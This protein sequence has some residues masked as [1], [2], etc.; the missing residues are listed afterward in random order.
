MPV[1]SCPDRKQL[2][3][4]LHGKLAETLA[5]QLAEHL[6][7][8]LDCEQAM[9]EIEDVEQVLPVDVARTGFQ[10]AIERVSGSGLHQAMNRLLGDRDSLLVSGMSHDGELSGHLGHYRIGGELGRGGMGTVYLA[11][12]TRLNREVALKIPR[13][14]LVE[15]SEILERLLREARAA[16]ALR[17]ANICPIYDTGEA[18][19]Q[20][21]I[22]MAYIQGKMLGKWAA[23]GHSVR[24][25]AEMMSTLCAAVAYAHA[26]GIV[27]RDL[28]P[29]NVMIESESNAPILMDFG[30]AVD[31]GQQAARTT[32]DGRVIGTPAY[33]A[34]EQAA[35]RI[36]EVGPAADV[37]ALGAILYE[38]LSGQVP[39]K[40]SLGEV[41]AKV[42][43]E[44]P[45]PLRLL[46]PRVHRDLE[47]IVL[48]CMAKEVSARYPTAAELADDLNRFNQGEPIVARRT[49]YL[50]KL[51][52]KVRRRPLPSLLAAAVAVAIAVTAYYVPRLNSARESGRLV[53]EVHELLDRDPWR[54]EDVGAIES[55]IAALDR[56]SN[57]AAQT[58]RM[59]LQRKIDQA[60]RNRLRKPRLDAGDVQTIDELLVMLEARAPQG[61]SDLRARRDER[62]RVWQLDIELVPPFHNVADG[63]SSHWVQVESDEAL[64][65]RPENA[66]SDGDVAVL[67]NWQS[68]GNTKIDA[69]F[70]GAWQPGQ[71]LGLMMHCD[72]GHPEPISSVACS[73]DGQSIAAGNVAGLISIWNVKS[74]LETASVRAHQAAVETVLYSPTGK[75]LATG[76]A[77]REVALWSAADWSQYATVVPIDGSPAPSSSL[78][79]AYP[80]AFSADSRYLA[81]GQTFDEVQCDV[82]VWDI[83]S[84]AE[85]ARLHGHTDA[86]TDLAFHPTEPNRL[87][88]SSI[89]GT[90]RLWDLSQ[91]DSLMT[92]KG[93]KEGDH[94]R[95]WDSLV[96][97]EFVNGGQGILAGKRRE[98]LL[99][100]SLGTGELAHEWETDRVGRGRDGLNGALLSTDHSLLALRHRSQL[101][102]WKYP[103][104][105]YLW[106]VAEGPS[107]FTPEGDQVV[108]GTATG[109]IVLW[110][111]Q[112]R[113]LESTLGGRSL[114]FMLSSVDDLVRPGSR[115]SIEAKTGRPPQE[116]GGAVEL[117]I[118][119]NGILLRREQQQ[120]ERGPI[121]L[122]IQNK[123]GLLSLQ[124]NDQKPLAFRDILP[125]N[126]PSAGVYGIVWS[127]QARLKQLKAYRQPLPP[128]GSPLE[129]GDVHYAAGRY[130]EAHAEYL[131]QAQLSGSEVSGQEMRREAQ[132]KSALCLSALGRQQEAAAVLTTLL[133]SNEDD[134]RWSMVALFQLW[135]L[136]VREARFDEAADLSETLL[137]RYDNDL[138]AEYVSADTRRQIIDAYTPVFDPN[139]TAFRFNSVRHLQTLFDAR[140]LLPISQPQQ[141]SLGFQLV[142]GLRASRLDERARDLASSLRAPLKNY[143]SNFSLTEMSDWPTL[144]A[145]NCLAYYLGDYTGPLRRI[146]VLL[147][148]TASEQIDW[149]LEQKRLQSTQS[150]AT[151]QLLRPDLMP[152]GYP[153]FLER[154]RVLAR[155]QQWEAVR[156]SIREFQ[157][158]AMLASVPYD[159]HA[160]A[161]LLDGIVHQELGDHAQMQAA[162]REARW[163]KW[164]QHS[165]KTKSVLQPQSAADVLLNYI[166]ESLA[167]VA[168]V[169]SARM[170]SNA[171]LETN[172][173]PELLKLLELHGE[174]P[175]ETYPQLW[176]TSLGQAR[177][178]QIVFGELLPAEQLRACAE[179]LIISAVDRGC[180]AAS[181]ASLHQKIIE[182]AVATLL[183]LVRT[184]QL[185][186][187]QLQQLL[188]AWRGELGEL[189]WSSR[190]ITNNFPEQRAQIAYLLGTRLLRVYDRADDAEKLF[191]LAVE[192]SPSDTTVY[193]LAY[194]ELQGLGVR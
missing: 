38:L 112:R 85:A 99:Q 151:A 64:S 174:L 145:H 50:R 169:Q 125:A 54:H 175:P 185:G 154:A 84:R 194:A 10:E 45:P 24:E 33:M 14:V 7:T 144:Q 89:D 137:L 156:D 42:Q 167:E 134:D 39:F 68:Q 8:C 5:E 40:G 126:R 118:L 103:E 105:Q 67:S 29:S 114:T 51:A 108:I 166:A 34:P 20:P 9:Q 75:W 135:L 19:G 30:L 157:R 170:T 63:F 104:M 123:D 86:I 152:Q 153:L 184:G 80:L 46:A 159:Q 121:R 193:R 164:Q 111:M 41:L 58:S 100:W 92:F 74:R 56:L 4:Y 3:E 109:S 165:R 187:T 180:P 107:C 17:H 26:K 141:D 172:G 186:S 21:Y 90:V 171:L 55:R 133:E 147:F 130:S 66:P 81:I 28:K 73:P 179:L 140:Q 11:H 182:E 161:H 160:L 192:S 101:D 94:D 188:F 22:A 71:Q 25:I 139:Y 102:I 131:Q 120:L 142:G 70:S 2:V 113:I 52:Y 191:R 181:H 98:D 79:T 189:G 61:A 155:S 163:T 43:H 78:C 132:C 162:W 117:S 91:R 44:E 177:V 183:G 18:N 23:E 31:V 138:L 106:T 97:V 76:A 35:G 148:G 116:L 15:D 115:N 48:K 62:L 119:R 32:Q 110:N 12:D 128:A 83:A 37:Y 53:Q 87:A 150:L 82:I 72:G 47:T 149:K 146:D 6:E 127:G 65:L 95:I 129:L 57:T 136:K 77:N 176:R 93:N 88:S 143:P 178:R 36:Y 27:H 60:I 190:G 13:Q 124:A 59:R 158:F 1:F 16:A 122:S 49:G 168:S 173:A 69:I 96:S